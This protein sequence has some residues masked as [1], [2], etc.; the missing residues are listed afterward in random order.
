MKIDLEAKCTETDQ[1]VPVAQ[2]KLAVD[3]GDTARALSKLNGYPYRT[4]D[5]RHPD[6]GIRIVVIENGL[7][8]ID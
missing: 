2:F 5:R 6:D 7:V 3:A 1:W 4:V 8:T